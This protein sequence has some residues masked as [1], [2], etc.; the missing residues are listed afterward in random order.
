MLKLISSL[1]PAAIVLRK[2]RIASSLALLTWLAACQQTH[3]VVPDN[4]PVASEKLTVAS[5]ESLQAQEMLLMGFESAPVYTPQPPLI[6]HTATPPVK[7]DLWVQLRKYMHLPLHL[8]QKRVQQEI[9]WLQRHPDYLLR[10]RARMQRY[11]PY[12]FT[13]V[14]QQ[15]LPAELALLPIVESALDTFAFS[16]GGAAG[17]WQFL[18]G[19]GK[20][21]GLEINQW[22]DGRR[23]IVASTDAALAY[24][25]DLHDRFD[26]WY[27]ALAGYNAGQGNVSKAR[28]RN[29]G[30]GF[31]DL[32]L[33]AETQAYVPRLLALVA[34]I[35]NPQQYNL[36]LPQVWPGTYFNTLDTH[37]QFQ[38]DKLAQTIGLELDSLYDWNPGISRWAT[39]PNGPHYVIVP[40]NI[41][42][43][44]AQQQIDQVP[45]KQRIDWL[46]IPIKSGDTLSHIAHRYHTDVASIKSANKLKSDRLRA[47]KRLLIPNN[48]N[49]QN[50]HPRLAG[51]NAG[52]TN[53]AYVVRPGDSMWSI[54]RAHQ[55]NLR[56]MLRLNQIGPRDTLTVGR[57]IHIPGKQKSA[58]HNPSVTRKVNYKVRRGDSLARIAN[59]FKVSIKQI[60]V[61]NNLDASRYLHPGQGLLLYVN[62]LGGQ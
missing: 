44:S 13:Q 29:P 38:L 9:R 57:T 48:A 39:P 7:P 37:S 62:V 36:E 42:V 12:L 8:E 50:Q 23:D 27:L 35:T 2:V 43:T 20:Q 54:A 6:A 24:L 30:A 14:Q 26:D 51:R 60:S 59:K 10:L 49:S 40:A 45:L 47:G 3:M 19:T 32:K 5:S 21:Y 61:W 4:L 34:V 11:L 52:G 15:N 46:E 18:R 41:D 55:V 22:Y 53:K 58:A 31:F 17:P 28:R 16:H 1:P 56:P 33:P 25:T